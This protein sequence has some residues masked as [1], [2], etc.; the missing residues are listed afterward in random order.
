[1]PVPQGAWE[2]G[3]SG[4]RKRQGKAWSGL[5]P[6]LAVSALIA[7]MHGGIMPLPQG[8]WEYGKSD[9][10][11]V[12]YMAASRPVVASPVGVNCDVMKEGVNG[13]LAITEEEGSQ[14][15]KAFAAIP[16]SPRRSEQRRGRR[17]NSRSPYAPPCRR[18]RRSCCQRRPCGARAIS[19]RALASNPIW[20]AP[21]RQTTPHYPDK[22]DKSGASGRRRKLHGVRRGGIEMLGEQGISG[23]DLARDPAEQRGT[24][25]NDHREAFEQRNDDGSSRHGEGDADSKTEHKER[26]ASARGRGDGDDV[27]ETHH[28]V[29]DGDDPDRL[30]Q[31]V[32][33]FDVPLAAVFLT[34]QQFDCDPEKQNTADKLDIRN[35]HQLRDDAGE[36]DPQGDGNQRAEHNAPHA[37]ARRQLA[38]GKRDDHGVVAGEQNVDPDDLYDGEPEARIFDGHCCCSAP[39]R[40]R[41]DVDSGKFVPNL[42]PPKAARTRHI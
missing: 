12:Q 8:A 28:Y 20:R 30:P 19:S 9:Y 7:T 13:F 22:Q 42:L 16:V 33:G 39:A 17:W 36:Y 27:V 5:S 34:A 23:D 11:L 40:I 14:T 10:K 4:S 18:S 3:K 24:G 21:P 25:P 2:Y 37:L 1:M 29:G 38:A 26:V 35:G 15:S 31:T 6:S 32:D 41:P